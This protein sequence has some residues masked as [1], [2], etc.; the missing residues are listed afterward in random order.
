MSSFSH[1]AT[2]QLSL[3]THIFLCRVCP[4][5]K[6][7]AS[8]NSGAPYI[9]EKQWAQ[10]IDETGGPISYPLSPPGPG[11]VLVNIKFSGV[12]HTDLHSGKGTGRSSRKGLSWGGHEGAGVVVAKGD[13]VKDHDVAIGDHKGVI[14]L[15]G[16]CLACEFCRKAD[17]PLCADALLSGYTV[18][19][20]PRQYCIAKAAHVAIIP[21][22][23]R[24]N[25][26]V[27]IL[28]ACITVYKGLKKSGARPRDMAA[29]VR[30]GGGLG[31][32]AQQYAMALGLRLL[33]IDAGEEKKEMC[34]Q[35]G[36][37]VSRHDD[38]CISMGQGD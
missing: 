27:P 32:V 30:A 38:C 8:K 5:S 15:N 19:R 25:A 35:L 21:K 14:W 20:T 37:D 11:K 7:R 18:D 12:C 26:V 22:H 6:K 34:E 1:P 10:V 31:T 36:V 13:L 3:Y 9:P 4:L 17:E 29:I 2:L 16:S 23:L 33:E 24:A 28:C